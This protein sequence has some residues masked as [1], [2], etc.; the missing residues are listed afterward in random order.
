M[1]REGMFGRVAASGSSGRTYIGVQV[2]LG[3]GALVAILA[4]TI[5]V[6]LTITVNLSRHQE[7]FSDRSVPYAQAVD[8]AALNAKAV[9]N[10]ERGFL[11]S[12][13]RGFVTEAQ[14]RA[15][16][17]DAAFAAAAAASSGP[18]QHRA[19]LAAHDG[20][21]AWMTRVRRE[22]ATYAAGHREWAIGS[23]MGTGR[24]LRKRYEASLGVAVGTREH[25]DPQ[26][27]SPH[28]VG[29]HAV[30]RDPRRLPPARAPV[31][32]RDRRVARALDHAPGLAPGLDA[33]LGGH[34]RGVAGRYGRRPNQ[35]RLNSPA[36]RTSMSAPPANPAVI[37]FCSFFVPMRDPSLS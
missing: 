21:G 7:S 25:G 16:R 34:R 36:S 35:R 2:W 24:A 29:V 27:R 10:D 14:S 9:A 31:R 6:A 13:D 32:R 8:E 37:S 18:A 30:G 17:A 5:I 28:G 3:L 12:G 19:V 11:I 4:A 20:F 22:F 15:R 23:S 1:S 33:Q 26:R